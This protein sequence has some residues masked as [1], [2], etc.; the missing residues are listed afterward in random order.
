MNDKD[1]R[2]T[3][4]DETPI[5]T[6]EH[7][8]DN[9][10]T[11]STVIN[12]SSGRHWRWIAASVAAALIVVGCLLGGYYYWI[13]NLYVGISVSTSPEENIEKLKVAAT[14]EVLPEVV[15]S[16]D[17]IFGVSMNIYEL[18]GL[19]AEISF[20]EPDSLDK[21]VYLYSR[22]ADHGGEGRYLGSLVKDGEMLADDHSRLGYFAAVGSRMVI[23]VARS[24]KVRDYCI[25]NKGS[26]FR[27]FILVSN[28]GI[29]GRFY[30]HGKVE[31]RAIGS[32]GNTLFY[33]E[34]PN[35]ETMWDFADA[36]R[37]Y[38]F[39][40]A[41]YIT[42]GDARGFYRTADGKSHEIGNPESL[43]NEKWKGI[44]PWLVFKRI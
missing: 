7:G 38:G 13:R 16:H 34:T 5:I 32:I 6:I 17:S 43:P 10:P 9:A 42:G 19:R 37:E 36:L 18:R 24:E 29:P 2:N 14:N 41:I 23:G 22:C 12:L 27:Q 31:R 35:K 33:I 28:G 15:M 4:M 1:V 40:D 11:A 8:G 44:I 21:D 26:F 30:L 39:T 25:E 20:E 3:E